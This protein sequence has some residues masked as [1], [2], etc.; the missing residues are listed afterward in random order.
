MNSYR[1]IVLARTARHAKLIRN[2]KTGNR[3]NCGPEFHPPRAQGA[4]FGNPWSRQ[5]QSRHDRGAPPRRRRRLSR[6]YEP[7][8]TCRACEGARRDPR[9]LRRATCR[10]RVCRYVVSP[11]VAVAFKKIKIKKLTI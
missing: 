6:Q 8:R 4:H 9:A 3:S 1:A 10:E 5:R 11:V 2:V 7:W